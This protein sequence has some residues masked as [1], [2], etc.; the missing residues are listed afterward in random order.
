MI[1][2]RSCNAIPTLQCELLTLSRPSLSAILR[3]LNF[4]ATM[5][6]ERGQMWGVW[7]PVGHVQAP[8]TRGWGALRHRY[9]QQGVP[10]GAGQCTVGHVPAGAGQCTVGHVLTSKCDSHVPWCTTKTCT[11]CWYSI[12]S[13]CCNRTKDLNIFL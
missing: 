10:A 5:D 4:T 6:N 3:L 7:G 11:F 1:I 9:T 12:S 13:P 2:R 8:A